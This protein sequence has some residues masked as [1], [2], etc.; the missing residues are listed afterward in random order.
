[1]AALDALTAVEVPA[2]QL[3]V[4]VV[5][6][7]AGIG[8]TVLWRHML[9]RLAEDR[10]LLVARPTEAEHDLPYSVLGD[11]FTTVP[12]DTFEGLLPAQRAAL[13]QALSRAAPSGQGDVRT[14]GVALVA[15]LD[16]LCRTPAPPRRRRR[17]PVDRP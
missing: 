17:R 7:P 2:G 12:D 16:G 8:K 5:E 4:I 10:H 15:T 6:G 1:L 11:L 13:E 14:T 3:R 9:D